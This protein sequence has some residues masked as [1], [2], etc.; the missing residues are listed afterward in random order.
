MTAKVLRQAD[1]W[2]KQLARSAQQMQ[3]VAG[4][5]GAA[6]LSMDLDTDS[7]SLSSVS[8]QDLMEAAARSASPAPADAGGGATA[9]MQVQAQLGELA[10]YVS[11][12]PCSV[13]WPP[14]ARCTAE[15]YYMY[16]K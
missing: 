7:A 3:A 2:Q 5:Q 1:E 4:Q 16:N 11:G 12:R 13:W 9:P 10:L 8:Q 15:S 14:E 6:D